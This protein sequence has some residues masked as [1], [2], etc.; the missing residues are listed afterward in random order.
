[1][2][3]ISPILIK[4]TITS[5]HNSLNTNMTTTRHMTLEIQVLDWDGHTIVAVL[6]LL[7]G[8]QLSPLDSWISNGNTYINKR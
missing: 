2:S 8:S 4:G 6:N 3:T 1:L 5:Q 7:M